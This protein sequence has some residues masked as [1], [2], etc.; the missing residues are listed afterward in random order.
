MTKYE[1]GKEK[2]ADVALARKFR[3]TRLELPARSS[4]AWGVSNRKFPWV[5]TEEE[6]VYLISLNYY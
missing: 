5:D 4:L 6:K 3:P 1:R 2:R